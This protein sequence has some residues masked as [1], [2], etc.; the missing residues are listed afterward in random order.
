MFKDNFAKVIQEG[1]VYVSHQLAEIIASKEYLS[2]KEEIIG[3]EI[4]VSLYNFQ[5][6]N[7]TKKN[8]L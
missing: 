5:N 6:E 1:H 7:I 3:N 8:T 4:E 2:N